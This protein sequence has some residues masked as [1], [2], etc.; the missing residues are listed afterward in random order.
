VTYAY[1]VVRDLSIGKKKEKKREKA[2]NVDP[3]LIV[4]AG[5]SSHVKYTRIFV[6]FFF[7]SIYKLVFFLRIK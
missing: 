5:I 1:N 6:C 7:Y 3:S 4:T 2:S